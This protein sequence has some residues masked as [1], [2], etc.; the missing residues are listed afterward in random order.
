[1]T[2]GAL[3][4]LAV[5]ATGCARPSL[6]QGHTLYM[7]NGCASCHGPDGHGDGPLAP[8]LPAAPIDFRNVT[9]FKRGATEDDI[10]ETLLVGV[11][12]VHTIPA[13]HLTHHELLMPKFDHLTKIERR[14]IALYVISLRDDANGRSAQP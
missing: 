2:L 8:H 14:S 1:M 12:Q 13:L 4:M 3:G 6:S 7:A 11:S 5:L 9:L 10:A